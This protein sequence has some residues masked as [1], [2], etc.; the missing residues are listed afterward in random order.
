MAEVRHIV[1]L[2]GRNYFANVMGGKLSSAGITQF[3]IGVD[4]YTIVN[5]Q[6]VPKV[7]SEDRTMLEAEELGH[8]VFS[9]NLDPTKLVVADRILTI[10]AEV[11][12]TEANGQEFFEVGLYSDTG[13]LV[14]YGTFPGILKQASF[15]MIFTIKIKF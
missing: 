2:V 11:L 1:T 12:E 4:G 14:V 10:T 8:Y 9:K 7:P 15:K 5:G 6:K 13:V 3:K